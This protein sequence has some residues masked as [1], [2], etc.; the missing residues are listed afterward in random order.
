M[1]FYFQ[2]NHNIKFV[3]KTKKSQS[4]DKININYFKIKKI[5]NIIKYELDINIGKY[6]KLIY[7]FIY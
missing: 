6:F 3:K 4:L 1:K 7:K 5:R 2:N